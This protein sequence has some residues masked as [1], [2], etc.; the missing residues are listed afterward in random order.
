MRLAMIGPYPIDGNENNITGGV[1][2]V[3]VSMIKGLSRFNDLDMHIITASFL[4]DKGKDFVSNGVKVHAVPLDRHFGNMTLY[5]NTRKMLRKKINEIKPDLIHAHMFGYYTLA[6]LDSGHKDIV[7]STHGISNGNWGLSYGIVQRVRRYMQDYIYIQCAK[8]AE[9]I[10]TNSPFAVEAV[11]RFGEKNI[12][13]LN[14]PVSEIFFDVDNTAE[15]EGRILFAGNI[16][17]AKGIMTILEAIK[18]VK[19]NLGKIK[20]MIAGGITDTDFYFKAIRFIEENNLGMSVNFLGHLSNKELK[21]EYQK[22]SLFVFP[23]QQDV[24]PLAVLQAMAAG[25]A[26]IASRVG[27]IPYMIDDGIN[28][29]LIDKKDHVFLA[30]KITSLINDRE[31]RKRLGSNARKKISRDYSAEKVTDRLYGIYQD[32]R[33]GR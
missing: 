6:A 30:E 4:I 24:A 9:N 23:S 2:A 14:N 33:G 19:N 12:Y 10:I 16:C 22:A 31:L 8:R 11:S 28:G 20:L 21:E 17:E 27:G 29:V 7:I 26:V 13:E 3:M 1:Q 25:K 32:L 18:I 5:S 15:E